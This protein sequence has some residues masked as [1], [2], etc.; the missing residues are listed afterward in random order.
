[1]PFAEQDLLP[2]ISQEELD[3]IAKELV[4]GG[5]PG[6]IATA[7]TEQ[8]QKV[9]DYTLRYAVPADRFN[10]LLRPLV[11]WELY[12]RLGEIPKKR[13]TAYDEAMKELRD[14]RDGK[15]PALALEDPAP[16]GLPEG[17]GNWGSATKI[18]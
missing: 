4:T 11:L 9:E 1:M 14:I 13:Q 10:R 5:D 8:T 12:K 6:P 17:Q 16:E 3:G 15:F 2:D 7:I 18:T